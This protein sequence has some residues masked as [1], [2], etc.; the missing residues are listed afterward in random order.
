MY[1][2]GWLTYT[3]MY[4][5]SVTRFHFSVGLEKFSERFIRTRLEE[6]EREKKKG[7]GVGEN[8]L[9]YQHLFSSDES[10]LCSTSSCQGTTSVGIRGYEAAADRSA[11]EALDQK[12]RYR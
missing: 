12:K 9:D 6:R 5:M 11:K 1:L 7:G 8:T 3:D 4:K 2:R 10:V